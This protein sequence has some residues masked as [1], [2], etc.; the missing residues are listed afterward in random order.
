MDFD[1]IVKDRYSV[2]SCQ[3]KKVEDDIVNKILESGRLAPTA[4]SLLI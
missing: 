2:S 3:D 1:D 4:S